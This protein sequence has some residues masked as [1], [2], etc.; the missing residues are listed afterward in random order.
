MTVAAGARPT[1]YAVGV[2][3]HA[4]EITDNMRTVMEAN[5][6]ALAEDMASPRD[7]AIPL[8]YRVGNIDTL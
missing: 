5:S 6:R 1:D 4:C 3:N 2:S 8:R 7:P